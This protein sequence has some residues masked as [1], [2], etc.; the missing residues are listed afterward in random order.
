[1]WEQEGTAAHLGITVS[2]FPNLFLLLGPNTGLGHNSVVFMIE[3]QARYVIQALDLLDRTGA[4]GLEVRAAAQRHSV[5]RVQSRLADTV[6]MSGCRSWYLDSNGRNV[7]IWPYF[8]WAY[9]VAT[10]RLRRRDFTL[11][12]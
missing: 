8:A 5:E 2:G 11:T 10:R 7:A 4:R 6:W 3:S 12:R 1:V 9:W